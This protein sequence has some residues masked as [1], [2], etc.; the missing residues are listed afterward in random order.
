MDLEIGFLWMKNLKIFLSKLSLMI[1]SDF[2]RQNLTY[3]LMWR[4]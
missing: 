4:K 1:Q 3:F 2:S